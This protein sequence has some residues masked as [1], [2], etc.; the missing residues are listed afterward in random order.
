MKMIGMIV[1]LLPD[2]NPKLKLKIN[3]R[4]RVS[5]LTWLCVVVTEEQF[6]GS[7]I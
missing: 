2:A 6:Y 7:F 4:D 1:K 5:P 3:A